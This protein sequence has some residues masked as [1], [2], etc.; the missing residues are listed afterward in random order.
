MLGMLGWGFSVEAEFFSMHAD[1]VRLKCNNRF[2]G[3]LHR[4][5][6]PRNSL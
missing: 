3:P 6:D 2:V 4:R 5:K 1:P